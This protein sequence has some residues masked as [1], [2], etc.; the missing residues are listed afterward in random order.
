MYAAFRDFISHEARE[1]R[2]QLG[3]HVASS[4]SG[5]IAGMIVA[6]MMWAVAVYFATI[7]GN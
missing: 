6:S 7:N 5:F 4:L 2:F 1:F 3:K